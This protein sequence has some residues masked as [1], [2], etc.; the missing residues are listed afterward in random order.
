MPHTIRYEPTFPLFLP[1]SLDGAPEFIEIDEY[2]CLLLFTNQAKVEQYH[3]A[4]NPNIK[5]LHVI[6]MTTF[7]SARELR[8]FLMIR[9]DEF[10]KQ[11][12]RRVAIDAHPGSPPGYALIRDLLEYLKS[13]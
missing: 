5:G 1:I 11:N 9:D 8:T 3:G 7:N 6:R 10:Q 12:C 4:R 2:V 13:V